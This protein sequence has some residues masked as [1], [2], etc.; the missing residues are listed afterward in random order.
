MDYTTQTPNNNTCSYQECVNQHR[1]SPQIAVTHCQGCKTPLVAMRM[2]NCPIC[3]EPAV[4]TNIRVD[5]LASAHP[6]VQKC[7]NEIHVGPEYIN[8]QIQHTHTNWAT[9]DTQAKTTPTIQE[10]EYK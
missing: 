5:Y 10:I 3:N 6:V 4:K 8:L 7:K 9:E 2:V 1:W